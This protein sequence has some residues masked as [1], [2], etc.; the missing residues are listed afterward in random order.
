[1]QSQPLDLV[2]IIIA[3]LSYMVSKDVAATVGPYAAIM[4]LSCAGAALSLSGSETEAGKFN[5]KAVWYVIVRIFLAV[6]LT[7][8]IAE[9]LEKLVPWL[10]PRYSLSPIAFAIGWIRDYDQVKTFLADLIKR[11]AEKRVDDG[12]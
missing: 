11:F 5:L 1:M 4:I 8:V 7:I 9:L 6:A 10:Q 3:V 12:K 2:G